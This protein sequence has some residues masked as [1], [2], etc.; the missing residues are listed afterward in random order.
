MSTI[1]NPEVVDVRRI[2]T[3]GT[4]DATVTVP[5]GT[6]VPTAGGNV[7]TNAAANVTATVSIP[8]AIDAIAA[9]AVSVRNAHNQG[10]VERVLDLL[11]EVVYAAREI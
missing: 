7:V 3:T 8:Q 10:A 4:G 11:R 1:Q 2:R 5:S 6:T 9:A